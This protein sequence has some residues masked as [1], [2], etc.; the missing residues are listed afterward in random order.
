LIREALGELQQARHGP[1]PLALNSLALI[2]AK[3]ASLGLGFLA[4]VVA[5]RLFPP[6]QVGLASAAVAA[7]M[8]CVQ[9]ALLGVGSSL[10]SLYPAHSRAPALLLDSA[11][12]NL[13]MPSSASSEPWPPHRQRRLHSSFF[14]PSG[15]SGSS[16]T[17]RP[18]RSAEVTRHSS[19]T[20]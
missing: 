10:I 14:P 4:W 19:G 16:W 7:M 11:A 12:S 13:R 1:L 9:L 17:R 18:R 5:A 2:T 6:A 8:L 20:W 15:H 3:V